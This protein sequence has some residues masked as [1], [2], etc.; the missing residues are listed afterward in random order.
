MSKY[1]SKTS[2]L[3]EFQDKYNQFDD[4]LKT[5]GFKYGNNW[6]ENNKVSTVIKTKINSLYG[7]EHYVHEVLNTS[8][9]FIRDKNEHKVV[10]INK[11]D[12]NISPVMNLD[13]AKKCILN[14]LIIKR[15][16]KLKQLQNLKFI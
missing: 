15:N 10:F 12:E 5:V 6:K 1:I 2:K 8:I 11:T 7:V 9:K 13:D 14:N 16:K 4:W 3:K